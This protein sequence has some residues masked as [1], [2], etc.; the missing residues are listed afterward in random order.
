MTSCYGDEIAPHSDDG[1]LVRQ[2]RDVRPRLLC[3]SDLLC[4]CRAA[5]RPRAT[6]TTSKCGTTRARCGA[7]GRRLRTRFA[8]AGYRTVLCGKMHFVGPD[9]LHGFEERWVPD[10]YPASIGVDAFQS[11]RSRREY[12][13]ANDS[14]GSRKPVMAKPT[15]CSTTN[16]SC[17]KPRKALPG[18]LDDDRPFLLVVSITGPHYPFMAPSPILGN[19]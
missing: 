4:P 3:L 16:S 6:P 9:Q 12:R 2:W 8:P 13:R 1:S 18:L 15:T 7:I 19:V 11:R 14:L 17:A 5:M 10:I